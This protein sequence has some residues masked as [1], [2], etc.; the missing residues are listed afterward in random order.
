MRPNPQNEVQQPR[1]YLQL[2]RA[3]SFE[4]D[5]GHQNRK[6]RSH[7][8]LVIARVPIRTRFRIYPTIFEKPLFGPR[9]VQVQ[10]LECVSGNKLEAQSGA[11]ERNEAPN[12]DLSRV[13]PSPVD[14]AKPPQLRMPFSEK[15]QRRLRGCIFGGIFGKVTCNF[16]IMRRFAPL[17]ARHRLFILLHLREE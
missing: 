13:I 17:C 11:F 2:Q 8:S 10:L 5:T 16:F 9:P 3:E 1:N 14:D 4:K 15:T 12:D 6:D 7:P